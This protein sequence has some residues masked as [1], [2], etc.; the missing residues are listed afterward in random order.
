MLLGAARSIAMI[1]PNSLHTKGAIATHMILDCGGGGGG[2][3]QLFAIFWA[4]ARDRFT[5][6]PPV[7]QSSA[8]ARSSISIQADNIVEI[9]AAD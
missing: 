8:A 2:G 3:H 1:E 6:P 5:I 9:H 4:T 7:A